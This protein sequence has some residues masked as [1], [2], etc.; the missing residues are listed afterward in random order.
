MRFGL[1]NGSA[2]ICFQSCAE[3]GERMTIEIKEKIKYFDADLVATPSGYSLEMWLRGPDLRYSGKLLK[4]AG[5]G[6]DILIQNYRDAFARY[7]ALVA[8]NVGAE[9]QERVGSLT[10]RVGGFNQGVCVDSYHHPI[11]SSV[12]L[13]AVISYLEA[14]KSR[15]P[16]LSKAARILQVP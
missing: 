9:M 5:T 4:I 3:Y 1:I 8:L 12:A 16:V 13:S 14:A 11:A 10:V 2:G 6:I 15:G 7:E